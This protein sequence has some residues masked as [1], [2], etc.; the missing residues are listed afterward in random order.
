MSSRGAKQAY[1]CPTARC[2]P[3]LAHPSPTP[4]HLARLP[5]LH[6]KGEA[7]IAIGPAGHVHL[8]QNGAVKTE[9]CQPDLI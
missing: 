1:L 8:E 6:A 5:L 9:F 7:D 2:A 4:A 3:Y